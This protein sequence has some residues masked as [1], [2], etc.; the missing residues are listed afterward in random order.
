MCSFPCRTDKKTRNF[1]CS[2]WLSNICMF[3]IG[4]KEQRNYLVL[5]S[6]RKEKENYVHFTLQHMYLHYYRQ[7]EKSR[8]ITLF[9]CQAEQKGKRNFSCSFCSATS[10]FTFSIADSLFDIELRDL[11]EDSW[12]RDTGVSAL[13]ARHRY[14]LLIS[15]SGASLISSLLEN[16][17]LRKKGSS[18]V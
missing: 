17:A 10:R 6:G 13:K 5:F 12:Y 16:K 4:R 8:E 9:L 7:N 15:I 11:F 3:Q 14:F 1:S 2:F 18:R